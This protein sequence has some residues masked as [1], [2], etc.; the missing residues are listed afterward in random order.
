MTRRFARGMALL[1]CLAMAGG[2]AA[3]QDEYVREDRLQELQEEMSGLSASVSQRLTS[4][5]RALETMLDEESESE[6]EAT[7]NDIL[8]SMEQDANTILEQISLNSPFMDSLDDARARIIV[9]IS[10]NEREP[11]SPSRDNRLARLEQSRQAY[12]KEYEAIQSAEGELTAMISNF[13]NVRREVMMESQVGEVEEVVRRLKDV[14]AQLGRMTEVLR[15]VGS[16][17]IDNPTGE[18]VSQ[19]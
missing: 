3:A 5:D 10:L 11:P 12:E 4:A 1:L 2:Q 15:D 13:A 6:R 18:T 17:V 9:L 14:T 19:E 8:D 7:I 16:T